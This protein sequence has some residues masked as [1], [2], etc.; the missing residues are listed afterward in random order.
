MDIKTIQE[1]KT[2][3]EVKEIKEGNEIKDMIAEIKRDMDARGGLK[4]VYFVACGGSQAAIAPGKYALDCEAQ[5]ISVKIYN[6]NEFV[7]A[8]P[9]SLDERCIVVA[10]SLKATPETVEA[11]RTAN[12]HG[13]V[14]IAMTGSPETG[15][16][17]VGQYVVTYSNGDDQV[18]SRSNQSQAL[19]IAYEILHA[20]EGWEK[21]DAAM[22]GFDQIDGLVA[23]A[24]CDMLPAARAFADACRD[25]EIFYVLGS[26]PLYWTAYTMENCHFLEMQARHA[27]LVHSGEYFHGPFE[28]TERG[29]PMILLM[30]TG[31]TRPLDER[32]RAFLE[33]YADRVF[34]IDAQDTGI[35][36]QIDPSVAE[37]FNSAIMIPIERFFVSQLAEVRNHP[38]ETRRYMWKVP[39]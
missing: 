13:A 11:V 20:F 31:R 5:D 21:Y 22:A 9:R 33:R 14:T 1:N 34:I 26:G 15:M 12:A 27:V 35:E 29:L 18:Y 2:I 6:S 36:G 19:R 7:H 25:D 39:Y 32:A 17:S 30:S 16:A 23:R 24:R 10:C 3:K 28:T 38:M 37:Y 8:P 4:G